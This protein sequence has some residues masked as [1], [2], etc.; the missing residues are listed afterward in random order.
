MKRMVLYIL[1]RYA[2]TFTLTVLSTPPTP[3][4]PPLPPLRQSKPLAVNDLATTIQTARFRHHLELEN[5]MAAHHASQSPPPSPTG[6]TARRMAASAL[7][8]ESTGLASVIPKFT[9][10]FDRQRFVPEFSTRRLPPD[11]KFA[12]VLGS[13]RPVSSDIGEG[14]FDRTILK[15]PGQGVKKPGTSSIVHTAP[16][17]LSPTTVG[18]SAAFG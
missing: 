8:R 12:R 11:V 4:P 10:E 3:P 18:V 14:A 15:S 17:M 13:S 1:R 7:L 6:E 2:T 16:Q 9:N 5:R